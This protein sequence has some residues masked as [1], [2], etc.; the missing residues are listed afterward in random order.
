MPRIADD[1]GMEFHAAGGQF[2][3]TG[4]RLEKLGATEYTLVDIAIDVTGS[5]AGFSDDLRNALIVAVDACKKSPR[6]DNLLLRVTT[7]STSVGGVNELHGYKPLGEIDTAQYP[8]F[9]PS[10]GTPLFDATYSAINSMVLYGGKLTDN[11]FLVNG[12]VFIITDGDDNN[13]TAT[14]RM[15]AQ[16]ISA[17]RQ[18]EKLESVV[19]VL[20]G[21][22][23]AQYRSYLANFK[24]QAGLDQYIDAG[25]ATKA[26]LA[27]LAD[28]VSQSV[29][30]QSQSLGT[31][32][33]SQNIAAT[34]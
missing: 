24:A 11:D 34:I 8:T 32:G 20:I 23:A 19:T 12:I 22:N 7:F 28:F 21:I 10:G 9:H 17:A 30:S 2:G 13:S 15:I 5:T 1:E 18:D 25:A 14:P 29:S 4:T 33:P 3:F 31:G 6:S 27:K 26:K 16:T